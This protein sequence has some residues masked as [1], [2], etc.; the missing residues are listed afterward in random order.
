[1]ESKRSEQAGFLYSAKF[2][3][4]LI[5]RLAHRELDLRDREKGAFESSLEASQNYAAGFVPIRLLPD[6]QFQELEFEPE[7]L[8]ASEKKVVVEVMIPGGAVLRIHER[9]PEGFV[10]KIFI[11]LILYFFCF[12]RT[13]HFSK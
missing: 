10:S 5:Q 4:V 3:A 13:I 7:R 12:V 8:N 1:V 11:I 2:A 9:C 6:K